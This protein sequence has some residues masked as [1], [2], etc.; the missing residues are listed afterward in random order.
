MQE[1]KNS[2]EEKGIKNVIDP[3]F[4]IYQ[5]KNI[6]EKIEAQIEIK[7]SISSL[8]DISFYENKKYEHIILELLPSDKH[9]YIDS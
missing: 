5:T 9:K 8:I 6:F 7:S 3:S 4:L 1:F 2:F